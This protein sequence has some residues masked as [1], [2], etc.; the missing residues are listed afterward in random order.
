MTD[1]KDNDNQSLIDKLIAV[2]HRLRWA[3]LLG[4]ALK[5][6]RNAIQGRTDRGL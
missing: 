2:L 3:D 4:D 1:E 5:A 6:V